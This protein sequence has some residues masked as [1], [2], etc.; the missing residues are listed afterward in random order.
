[1][2]SSIIGPNQR[3]TSSR[4]IDVIGSM[5]ATYRVMTIPPITASA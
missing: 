2:T 3:T 5:R 1:M 4:R